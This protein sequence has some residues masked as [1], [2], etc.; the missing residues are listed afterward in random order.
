MT[1]VSATAIVVQLAAR[2]R[3]PPVQC[4]EGLSLEHGR[5]CGAGQTRTNGR[6]VG[7]PA[8][9]GPAQTVLQKRGTQPSCVLDS[10]RVELEGGELPPGA[11]DWQL[12]TP[13]RP[14]VVP[15]FRI[16]RGEVT[17]SRYLEC[18]ERQLC[19][20]LP[21]VSDLGLPVTGIPPKI[22]EEYCRFTGGR[23]PTSA[24]WRFAASG[25][26]G[27]RFPW[28][29]TGLVCRRA[30]FGL[31]QGPCSSEGTGPDL[32]GARPDGATPEGI[33]D[34]AGN[35][36]EWTRDPDGRY[37]ARG[38]SF[39]SRVAA[40]LVTAAVESPPET[41]DHVGFRCAYTL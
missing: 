6:C 14:V 24:E 18:V 36:A 16:D 20:P 38:G 33:L 40:E 17:V 1:A 34:L 21:K 8:S 25:K 10:T 39:R 30:A 19:P 29:F 7:K 13:N 41:A 2:E 35:V 5:C 9:C 32:A 37:R 27:R 31:V 3:T 28:G 22:A 23:L 15:R 26:Q 11:A 4:A 12:T